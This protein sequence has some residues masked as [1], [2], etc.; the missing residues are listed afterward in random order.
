M[1]LT[2]ANLINSIRN[3]CVL[4]KDIST[5]LVESVLE[6]MKSTLE[7]GE[8]VLIS[9][10][11]KFCVKDKGERLGRN[12]STGGDLPLRDR[13]IVTFKCSIVLREKMNRKK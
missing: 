5:N 4:S 10:F 9:G 6:M 11:G 1:S 12:P 13:R 3:Q 8:D 2:K 7:S